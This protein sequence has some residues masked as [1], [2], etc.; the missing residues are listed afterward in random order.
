MNKSKDRI[1]ILHLISSLEVGGAEKLLIDLLKN[2]NPTDD[3]YYIAVV[4]NDKVNESLKKELLATNCNVY[5]LNRKEGHKHPK[6]LFRLLNIIKQNNI[7]II[8]SHNYGGKAWSMLCK[9][10]NPK[11][12]LVYTIHDTNILNNLSKLNLLLHKKFIDT[13]I[14]ISNAILKECQEY[15][16]N[17]TIQI[18]NGVN[19]KNFDVKEKNKKIDNYF[20]IINISRI[21][22]L[23]K[24]QDILINALKI[25]KDKGLNFKCN[26][27]GG[28]YD[29]SKDSYKYLN[30]LVKELN[31]EKEITFLGNRTDICEL[32]SASDLFV[33]S[34]KYEGLGLV[35]LESMSA[36][37]PVITSNIDGPAELITHGENGLLFESENHYDLA[38]KILY[39]YNNR[40]KMEALSQNAYEYVQ[41]FDIFVM[42]EKYCDLYKKLNENYGN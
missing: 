39:L 26:F 14:A 40:K 42:C 6:Y 5:F 7:D 27:V 37:V 11:L 16:I 1:N 8:H 35:V 23:K 2:T 38:D 36:R 15:N 30:T 13:N 21:N 24:G 18:Y 33:L 10:L 25:C 4:M 3:V 34:S 19:L 29:Y 32:L 12:K 28:V 41:R 20:N 31:L 22:H 17:E 9:W